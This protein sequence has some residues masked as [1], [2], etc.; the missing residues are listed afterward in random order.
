MLAYGWGK[1][2]SDIR[3]VERIKN[4]LD[5][6]RRRQNGKDDQVD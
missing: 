4:N 6:S 2:Y 1:K 5:E 3:D